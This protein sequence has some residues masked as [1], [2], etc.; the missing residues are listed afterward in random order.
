MEASP[1]KAEINKER[2]KDYDNLSVITGNLDAIDSAEKF[3][4]ITLIGSLE[5][6]SL[7]VDGEPADEKLLEKAKALLNPEGKIIIAVENK[8]GIKYWAGAQDSH[9]GQLFSG[10]TGQ[11]NIG[12]YYTFSK[13]SL[14]TL[15]TKV[16][17]GEIMYYYPIPDYKTPLE[18]YS[19]NNI[20]KSGEI[21]ENSPS[22][23]KERYLL[24]DEGAAL[25]SLCRDGKF[26]QFANSFLII[27]R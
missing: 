3:D 7:Y 22:Y 23:D 10:I 8:Y 26:E 27:T 17:F 4:Y 12:N 9:F 20:P 14:D 19:M 25:S 21:M 16:G 13:N 5:E 6:S 18:I 1:I 11:E 24:F 15:I 2:N